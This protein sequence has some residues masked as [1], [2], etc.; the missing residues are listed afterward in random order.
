VP[1]DAL[2]PAVLLDVGVGWSFIGIG[3][4]ARRRRPGSRAGT[5]MVAVGFAWLVRVSGAVE[6]PVGYVLGAATKTLYLGVLAHL[7]VTYPSGRARTWRQRLLVVLGYL[8]TAPTGLL[9]LAVVAAGGGCWNCPVN[10]VVIQPVPASTAPAGTAVLLVVLLFAGVLAALLGLLLG[11]WL[12]AGGARRRELTPAVWGGA[13]IVATTLAQYAAA[14]LGAAPRV[15]AALAWSTGAVL[16]GWPAA[17]LLGLLRSRLDRA[18]AG[19]LVV[20]SGVGD[21]GTNV[22]GND[23]GNGSGAGDGA[24]APARLRDAVAAALHDPS[25]ELVFRLPDRPVFVDPRGEPVD[26]D[27]PGTGRMVTP[28]G[29]GDPVAAVLHSD[30]LADEPELL[31]AVVAGAAL[32]VRNQRLHAAARA[33]LVEVTASRRRIVRAGDAERRRIERDLHDGAQQRLVAVA[34]TIRLAR[35]Q[36]GGGRGEAAALVAEAAA[37]LAAAV[38]ELRELASGVYPAALAEAGLGAALDALAARSAVPVRVTADPGVRLPAAVEHA[39]WFTASELLANAAKHA[40]ARCVEVDLR[41][42]GARVVLRVSDDGV[43]GADPDGS[44]LR[45]L[46]DRVASAGGH[47]A[48]HS[49]AGAGTRA[50]VDFPVRAAAGSAAPSTGRVVPHPDAG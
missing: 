47:L 5:L 22:S 28:I 48:L 43:G 20:G 45:G 34:L 30:A 12:M 23:S 24:G 39:C 1:L 36:V 50:V 40:A 26:L 13:A 35:A 38:A 32:A 49:P 15:Q 31:D 17:L 25:A 21:G 2:V 7:L 41:V 6:H 19:P 42:T 8:L 14:V 11:R 9:Y 33:R 46:A 10:I 27:R 4:I 29:D 37:E 44:G 18:A 3:L 16:I